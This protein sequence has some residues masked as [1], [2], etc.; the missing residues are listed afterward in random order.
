MKLFRNTII[1]YDKFHIV[2]HVN[3][4]IERVRRL[5]IAYPQKEKT[6]TL[7]RTKYLWLINSENLKKTQKEAFHST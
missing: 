4:A 3:G 5:K 1:V 2:K 6:N 7:K